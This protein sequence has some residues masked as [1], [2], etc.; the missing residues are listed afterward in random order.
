MND[1]ILKVAFGGNR[2]VTSNALWQYDYGQVL[3]IKGITLPEMYEV[4]FSVSDSGNAYV[5]IGDS[6]GVDIPDALLEIGDSIYA[7]IYLH[8]GEDDGETEYRI[9]IPVHKRAKPT[10]ETPTPVQQS[11]IER[12]IALC[13]EIVEQGGGGSG[14]DGFS[15]VVTVTEITGGYQ[16]S[17]QDK[18]H[19]ETFNI[20]NGIDGQD[21]QNGINGK[22]GADGKD[23]KDGINGTDGSDGADGV[24]PAITIAE[25]TGGHAITITDA[26]HPTGQTFNVMDGA[27]GDAFTY[28]DFTQQ[29]LA[30]LKGDDGVSPVI[31]VSSITNG[32]R[33]SVT[34]ST[35]TETF[36]VT[37]GTNGTNG[38]DYVLTAQD[39][40]D[41]AN[42]V[43]NGLPQAEGSDF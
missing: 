40:A 24:S 19:T 22:D 13:E 21:G 39:K 31:A 9:V 28:A 38:Q 23:G 37:N 17:I 10:H 2:M 3:Q 36:D 12:L 4:H 27:K 20:M 35:H 26:L 8:T 18:T 34:D 11:E 25:I 41:I 29:Q 16:L 15:P 42:L 1:N 43:M 6:D 33:V 14:S 5:A 32:H 30:G 7:H